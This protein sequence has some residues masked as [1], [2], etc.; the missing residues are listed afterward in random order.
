VH[1]LMRAVLLRRG[2]PDTLVLK[3]EAHPPDVQVRETAEGPR[4]KRGPMCFGLA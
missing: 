4:H 1:A 3:A 2:G